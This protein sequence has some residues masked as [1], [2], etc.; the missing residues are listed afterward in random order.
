MRYSPMHSVDLIQL[1]KPGQIYFSSWRWV[2]DFFGGRKETL[3]KI[4]VIKDE[5]IFNVI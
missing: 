3:M 5:T 2:A 4:Y 1:R